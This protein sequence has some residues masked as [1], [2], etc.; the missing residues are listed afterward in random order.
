MSVTSPPAFSQFGKSNLFQ[1]YDRDPIEHSVR[2]VSKSV[3]DEKLKVDAAAV[4]AP[5]KSP[6]GQL[7]AAAIAN[8]LNVSCVLDT[9]GSKASSLSFLRRS[10]LASRVRGLSVNGCMST[11]DK[12]LTGKP[13]YGVFDK[14]GVEYAGKNVTASASVTSDLAGQHLGSAEV[15]VGF[16]GV[17]L[18]A[19]IKLIKNADKALA[20]KSYNAGLV[21]TKGQYGAAL[22]SD[23]KF[24]K[25]KL[26][27]LANKL[28][29]KKNWN[30]GVQGKFDV[31]A[32]SGSAPQREVIAGVETA[33]TPNTTYRLASVL[34][35]RR[36]VGSVEHRLTNPNVKVS[37]TAAFPL[38]ASPYSAYQ[39]TNFGLALTFG[40]Y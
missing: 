26:A 3:S 39:V 16:E 22:V 37:A 29:P 14:V 36:F 21:Y 25:L 6:R 31:V 27:L 28:G 18:G 30:V 34:N 17:S 5:N 2:L 35:T 24:E 38:P 32:P 23:S 40:D 15:S 4:Y 13:A 19:D 9:D 7:K 8:G 10:V 11:S 12:D 20:P 33:A 1:V